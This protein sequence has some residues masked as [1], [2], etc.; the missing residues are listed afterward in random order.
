MFYEV[1]DSLAAGVLPEPVQVG[2]DLL[3]QVDHLVVLPDQNCQIVASEVVD[4]SFA[5]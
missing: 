5:G 2:N 4:D 3:H 1:V